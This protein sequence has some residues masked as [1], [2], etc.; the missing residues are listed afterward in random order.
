VTN[1]SFVGGSALSSAGRRRLY[2][3]AQ[4]PPPWMELIDRLAISRPDSLS[5]VNYSA[6]VAVSLAASLWRNLLPFR[7]PRRS[8]LSLHLPCFRVLTSLTCS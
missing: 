3:K 6:M 5:E 1:P 7:Q 8:V 4:G 2:Q